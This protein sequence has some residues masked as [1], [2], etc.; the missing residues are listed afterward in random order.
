MRWVELFLE[1]RMVCLVGGKSAV[2]VATSCMVSQ[3]WPILPTLFL[4]F[5]NDLLCW[6]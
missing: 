3:G 4:V 6:L 1:G 5:I 2:E